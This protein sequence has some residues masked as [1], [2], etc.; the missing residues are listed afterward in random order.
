MVRPVWKS[1]LVA[2]ASSLFLASCIGP[3]SQPMRSTMNQKSVYEPFAVATGERLTERCD[4][5][6][7]LS[8]LSRSQMVSFSEEDAANKALNVYNDIAILLGDLAAESSL[9]EEVH[10]DEF[11]RKAAEE[12]KQKISDFLTDL[13]LDKGVY[14]ALKLTDASKLD[15]DG[16]RMLEKTLR[17]FRRSGVDKDDATREKIRALNAELVK[18]GQDF[19]KN[20]RKETFFIELDSASALQGLPQDYIDQHRQANGTYKI[21]TDY[22]DFVPFMEYAENDAARKDLRFKYLNRGSENSEVLKDLIK[23]RKEL[24][25]ALGYPSYAAFV[26]EDKMIK[27]TAAV[28]SFIAKIADLA[29]PGSQREFAALLEFK[30]RTQPEATRIEGHEA[31][32]LDNLYKKEKFGFDS[33]EARG[34]FPY[35]PV[36]DG[37]M[38]VTGELFG[39]TYHHVPDAKVWHVEVDTYDVLDRNTGEVLG[40]IY[41][42]M[43]PRDGKFKHAAQFTMRN[44]ISNQRLPEGALVCNF[45]NPRDGDGLALMQHNEV[46]TFFHEFGHLLHHVFAGKQHWAAFSG[47]ATEWDFVEAPSQLLEEWAW[48]PAVLQT[49]AFHHETKQPISVELVN[50]MRAADEFGKAIHARQQMFY[51]AISYNFFAKSPDS[52]DPVS[53]MATL[54]GKYSLYPYE[55]GTH[56]IYNFGHL[57]DYSAIY[58]TYMWSL[59]LAKDL[60][61]PF[62]THGLMDRAT[63]QRYRNLVLSRGGSKDASV[64]VEEFLGRPFEF[65]AFEDWLSLDPMVATSH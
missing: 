39:I 4:D 17:D 21:T 28:E 48:S 19:A 52:F 2:L 18:I 35:L 24:A 36:R 46:V 10:P 29:E 23:R 33:Q 45:P 12:C 20:I 55:P 7:K 30:K 50:K 47:V 27:N 65:R 49:F 32:Y 3:K 59:S 13:S 6:L 38:K 56:F 57:V 15:A 25:D 60:L 8:T 37:L 58:Y 22:P 43:H 62:L 54:Q 42:D 26:V 63:A 53:L 16:T 41:L 9:M 40:R 61:S 5:A 64:L 31:A 1:A 14:N 11:V 44:G 34:Y 51:A